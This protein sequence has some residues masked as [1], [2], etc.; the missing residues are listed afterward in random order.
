MTDTQNGN[1]IMINR[2]TFAVMVVAMIAFIGWGSALYNG[3]EKRIRSL[4]VSVAVT[5]QNTKTI[6]E[7]SDDIA[8]ELRR[9]TQKIEEKKYTK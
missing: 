5:E 8:A 6:M 1:T 2:A 3:H 7:Q 9:L 4:E